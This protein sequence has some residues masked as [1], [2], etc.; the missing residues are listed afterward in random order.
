LKDKLKV[1]RWSLEQ[2]LSSEDKH[3]ELLQRSTADPLFQSFAWL[4]LWW[5]FF[6]RPEDGETVSVYAAHDADRLIGLMPL[7][8]A[9]TARRWPLNYKSASFLGNRLRENRGIPTEYQDVIA[10]QGREQEVREASLRAFLLENTDAELTIGWTKAAADWQKAFTAQQ[11]QSRRHTRT[12]DPQTSYQVNLGEGF[13][14]YTKSLSANAR[15]ALLNQRSQLQKQG[16]VVSTKLDPA[17]FAS[18]LATLNEL[19]SKRWG[20]VAF[21]G[22]K[23]KFHESLTAQ[24]PEGCQ[25]IIHELSIAGQVVSSLYDIRCGKF[26]YNIQMGFDNSRLSSGSLGILHLGYALEEAASGG[27]QT[28]D[29]LGGYGKST[30][31]KSRYSTQHAD[32]VSTQTLL[33]APVAAL[34]RAYELLR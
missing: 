32:L 6:G 34:Y 5:K 4:S 20:K 21:V 2:W 18:G 1:T 17:N 15:R 16:T 27:V 24:L 9:R 10:E 29:F 7:H 13:S 28:Y 12:L 30:D 19:H 11:G 14:A 33:S 25:G 26:Q 23:I 3:T 8:H 22:K 31:Y